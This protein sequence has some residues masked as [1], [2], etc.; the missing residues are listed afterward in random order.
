MLCLSNAMHDSLT[1]THDIAPYTA[2]FLRSSL[3]LDLYLLLQDGILYISCQDPK[4]RS[5][6]RL[7]TA[8]YSTQ[9]RF[10]RTRIYITTSSEIK[11]VNGTTCHR[12]GVAGYLHGLCVSCTYLP[13]GSVYCTSNHAI[14]APNWISSWSIF[15]WKRL[16]GQMRRL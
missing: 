16:R 7:W 13:D 3:F 12:T 2:K 14:K 5:K 15:C 11:P 4:S 10:K 9:F 6:R 1:L 8:W